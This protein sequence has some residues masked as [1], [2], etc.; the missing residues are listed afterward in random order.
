MGLGANGPPIP[1]PVCFSVVPYPVKRKRPCIPN[2]GATFEFVHVPVPVIE[3]DE[4]DDNSLE[5]FVMFL[6]INNIF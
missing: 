1:L 2:N 5:K 4:V 3:T 6:L